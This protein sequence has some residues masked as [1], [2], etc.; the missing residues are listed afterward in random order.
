LENSKGAFLLHGANSFQF[1]SLVSAVFQPIIT[2]RSSF[3]VT[4]FPLPA[5]FKEG[6]HSM[7]Y[8]LPAES[9]KWSRTSEIPACPAYPWDRHYQSYCYMYSSGSSI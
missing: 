4:A 3:T 8:L 1:H 9:S 7:F 2:Q 5:C 6:I